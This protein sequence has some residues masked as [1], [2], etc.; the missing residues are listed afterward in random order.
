M[1]ECSMECACGLFAAPPLFF[2]AH[3][4]DAITSGQPAWPWGKL[5]AALRCVNRAWRAAVDG[6]LRELSLS[7]KS[8]ERLDALEDVHVAAAWAARCPRLSRLQ[9][10]SS[11]EHHQRA[12]H[13]TRSWLYGWHP[14]HW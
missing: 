8:G 1:H 11:S 3:L 12:R 14:F 10:N 6:C 5:L 4:V 9:F 13:A 2:A 7:D